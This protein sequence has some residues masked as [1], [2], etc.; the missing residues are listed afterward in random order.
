MPHWHIAIIRFA[1]LS[2]PIA[3]DATRKKLEMR[4]PTSRPGPAVLSHR[5]VARCAPGALKGNSR[6]Q[7]CTETQHVGAENNPGQI[8]DTHYPYPNYPDPNPNYP[9]PRYPI[10]NSD[11]DFDYPKLVWVIRVISPDTRI[12]RLSLSLYISCVVS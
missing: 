4:P 3:R 7:P 8:T 6:H 12:T 11:S 2:G 5:A 9:N 1:L 10:L